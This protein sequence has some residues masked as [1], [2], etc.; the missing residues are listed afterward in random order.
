[1][2]LIMLRIRVSIKQAEVI[3][4]KKVRIIS[5]ALV[6]KGSSFVHKMKVQVNYDGELSWNTGCLWMQVSKA[7]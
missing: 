6:Q 1:M 2:H 7:L 3:K 4:L 5:S